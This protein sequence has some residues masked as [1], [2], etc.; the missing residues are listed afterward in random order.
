MEFMER[1]SGNWICGWT[2]RKQTLWNFQTPGYIWG[3]GHWWIC[4]RDPPPT[5]IAQDWIEVLLPGRYMLCLRQQSFLNWSG[6]SACWDRATRGNNRFT[7]W[8]DSE[9]EAQR[10]ISIKLWSKIGLF[11]PNVRP[12]CCSQ[13]TDFQRGSTGFF[14]LHRRAGTVLLRLGVIC[15]VLWAK[16]CPHWLA[17]G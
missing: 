3:W 14:R 8:R 7:G 10:M 1:L 12:P 9:N 15:D 11:I 17:C 2:T 5:F 16:P 6:W 4:S 13:S